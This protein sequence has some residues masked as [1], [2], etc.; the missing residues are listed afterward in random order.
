MCFPPRWDARLSAEGKPSHCGGKT[1]SVNR[2]GFFVVVSVINGWGGGRPLLCDLGEQAL[3]AIM[4]SPIGSLDRL[5]ALWGLLCKL[6]SD[7][8]SEKRK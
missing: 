8:A 2:C 7:G 6:K 5:V 4:Y 3:V 1:I